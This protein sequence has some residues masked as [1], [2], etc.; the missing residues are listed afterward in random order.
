[1][2]IISK[3][4]QKFFN[5]DNEQWEGKRLLYHKLA[6]GKEQLFSKH[7]DAAADGTS[8]LIITVAKP[9]GESKWKYWPCPFEGRDKQVFF[10]E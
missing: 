10:M 3:E 8:L 7:L 6:A 2:L 1:M 4:T 9:K 5:N